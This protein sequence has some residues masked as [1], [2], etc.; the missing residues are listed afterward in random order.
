MG[1]NNY[2]GKGGG[3]TR[4]REQPDA[5]SD[6][7][8]KKKWEPKYLQA[9]DSKWHF[10]KASLR[11]YPSESGSPFYTRG[12]SD[13]ATWPC[14][15]FRPPEPQYRRGVQPHGRGTINMMTDFVDRYLN[16]PAVV[17]WERS[18]QLR[19]LDESRAPRRTT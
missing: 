4:R 1:K 8:E 16:D 18:A 17:P 12:M 3:S 13:A 9:V 14:A 2:K 10:G 11:P 15:M 19:T 6:N 5:V 7:N